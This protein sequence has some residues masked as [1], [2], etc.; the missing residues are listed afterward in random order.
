MYVWVDIV[1]LYT[2]NFFAVIFSICSLP[3]YQLPHIYYRIRKIRSI[4]YFSYLWEF[5]GL[6]ASRV[7]IVSFSPEL[8]VIK[9]LWT[10]HHYSSIY[11]P[12]V[13]IVYEKR[14]PQNEHQTVIKH[15][16]SAICVIMWYEQIHNHMYNNLPPYQNTE[17]SR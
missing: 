1:D 14:T 3:P 15:F 13:C 12:Y 7:F 2:D 16:V 5:P 11:V 17:N 9:T 4:Y 8:V 10:E 6:L